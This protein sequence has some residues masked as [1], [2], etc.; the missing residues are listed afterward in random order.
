MITKHVR[1]STIWPRRAESHF[2]E[3]PLDKQ[4][5]REPVYGIASTRAVSKAACHQQVQYGTNLEA[6][7]LHPALH[8]PRFGSILLSI[9]K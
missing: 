4:R 6:Y 9:D 5:R 1:Q 7:L 3:K 8:A 2:H